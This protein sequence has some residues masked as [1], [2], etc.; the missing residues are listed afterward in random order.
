MSMQPT[1]RRG[2][3]VT[4]AEAEDLVRQVF[5][6]QGHARPLPGERDDNFRIIPDSAGDY[7]LKIAHPEELQV[8]LEGQNSAMKAIGRACLDFQVPDVLAPAGDKEVVVAE[9]RGQ[10]RLIRLLSFV[11]G[12][13]LTEV[14]TRDAA[15]LNDI[16][17]TFGKIDKTLSTFR[18]PGTRRE[19]CWDLRHAST[20]VNGHMASIPDAGD[21]AVV[22]HFLRRFERDV[23]PQLPRLRTS[24][25]HNDGNDH[26][27][28]VT[29][30]SNGA[31]R[32]AGIV[33]FGD[34]VE[35][36]TVFELAIACAYVML[37]QEDLLGAAG[38][39][40]AGYHEVFPL[41]DAEFDLLFDLMCMRLCVSVTV[42]ASR[43]VE[44][45]T[46]TYLAVTEMA[47]WDTLRRLIEVQPTRA[48]QALRD[49]SV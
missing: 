30:T 44:K 2:S 43:S 48:M 41:S 37:D 12:V 14:K 15:L 18:H 27:V 24:V 22:H 16:G 23:E 17:R 20:V 34:M 25:I 36:H 13:P 21:R 1:S 45:E 10:R 29:Q 28:L 39:V 11:P 5:G 42:A 33:D 40:S 6:V 49:V 31:H 8:T 46:N 19:L 26:N 38:N 7:I 4:A 3:G 35:S 47:A 32:V 9:L